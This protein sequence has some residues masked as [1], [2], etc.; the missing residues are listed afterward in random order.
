MVRYSRFNDFDPVRVVGGDREAPL[1]SDASDYAPVGVPWPREEMSEDLD[2]LQVDLTRLR[3]QL[4]PD[5]FAR[6]E[7]ERILRERFSIAPSGED[8][9]LR[10]CSVPSPKKA[11]VA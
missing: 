5:S 9:K 7:I 2:Y 11:K 8:D 1:L 4:A 6:R 3:D 10:P